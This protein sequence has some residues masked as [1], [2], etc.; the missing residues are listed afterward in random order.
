MI[1]MNMFKVHDCIDFKTYT[2]IQVTHNHNNHHC[3]F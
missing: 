1:Q 2:A 3:V